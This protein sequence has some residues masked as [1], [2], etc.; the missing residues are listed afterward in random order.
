M[1]DAHFVQEVYITGAHYGK[2]V[3]TDAC[4]IPYHRWTRM[5]HNQGRPC[6]SS[7]GINSL[8]TSQANRLT[9]PRLTVQSLNN[10]I[11]HSEIVLPIC[12]LTYTAH[13][14]KRPD[15]PL[16]PGFCTVGFGYA[17]RTPPFEVQM[18]GEGEMPKDTR[19]VSDLPHLVLPFLIGVFSLNLE[20]P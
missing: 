14:F 16:R 2:Y 13:G 18:F 20:Y 19:T 3:Y 15:H 5:F 8:K 12:Q 11:K 6:Q 7:T 4:S 10:N 9:Q 17:L 1:P